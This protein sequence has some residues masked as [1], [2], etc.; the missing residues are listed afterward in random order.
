[1]ITKEDA[2][3]LESENPKELV[4]IICTQSELIDDLYSQL[5][6]RD[7]EIERLKHKRIVQICGF[8]KRRGINISMELYRLLESLNKGLAI[9]VIDKKTVSDLFLLLETYTRTH[10]ETFKGLKAFRLIGGI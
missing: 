10:F 4:D 1:M 8:D 6:Q 7:E 3:N 2:D 5:K 9:E